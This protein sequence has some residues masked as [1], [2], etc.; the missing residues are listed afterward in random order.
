MR[1]ASGQACFVSFSD[2]LS[3]T[4]IISGL[5]H[6]L[7]C[8]G[9]RF[10]NNNLCGRTSDSGKVCRAGAVEEPELPITSGVFLDWLSKTLGRQAPGGKVRH[11]KQNCSKAWFSHCLS[12][13]LSP[14]A[15]RDQDIKDGQSKHKALL[16][17]HRF[18]L[19]HILIQS[20]LSLGKGAF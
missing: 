1:P 10:N 12:H 16:E 2:G 9:H 13:S 11:S 8:L 14:M 19:I 3:K 7:G 17:S 20:K 6:A 5:H 18:P 4:T 15:L